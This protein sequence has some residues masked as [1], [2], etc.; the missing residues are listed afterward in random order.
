V[1]APCCGAA[2]P[3]TETTYSS[4]NRLIQRDPGGMARGVER[5]VNK[6]NT[7]GLSQNA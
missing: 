2:T 7:K 6:K 3:S 5:H 1:S 4:R